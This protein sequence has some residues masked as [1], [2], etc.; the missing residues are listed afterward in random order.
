MNVIVVKKMSIDN[1]RY[2]IDDSY[3]PDN[4]LINLKLDDGSL[5][6]ISLREFLLSILF[7][8]YD[9]NIGD[10]VLKSICILFNTYSYMMMSKY[11]YI[12]SKNDFINFINYKEYSIKYDNYNN[13]IDRFNNIINS[14]SCMYMSYNNEFILPFIHL[15]NSGKT[16]SNK[17]YP[18]LSSVKSLWDLTSPN[19]LVIHDFNYEEISN[20]LNTNINSNTKLVIDNESIYI[21]DKNFTISEIKELLNLNSCLIDIIQNKNSIRFITRGIGNGLG[22]S[23]YGAQSIEENGGSYITILSY[24]FPKVQINRYIKELS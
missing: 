1:K 21:N 22:L 7:K 18:Y 15:C 6:E 16:V 24:Y 8:Y 2:D 10:E 13:I 5:C 4:Y 17:D 11:N 23:L 3:N 12:D 14:I 9:N 19:Y 20:L